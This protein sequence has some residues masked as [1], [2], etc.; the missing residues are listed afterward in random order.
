MSARHRNCRD[1]IEL[2][3]QL[4]AVTHDPVA[5]LELPTLGEGFVDSAHVRQV[6][7][8]HRADDAHR[9]AQVTL[10]KTIALFELQQLSCRFERVVEPHAVPS[11]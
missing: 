9:R 11:L 4:L 7:P 10:G 1:A 5:T 2:A 3:R 8:I 6:L